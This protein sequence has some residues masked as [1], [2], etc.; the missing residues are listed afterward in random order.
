MPRPPKRTYQHFLFIATVVAVAVSLAVYSAKDKSDRITSQQHILVQNEF[1]QFFTTVRAYAKMIVVNQSIETNR[2]P[3]IFE[4]TYLP[5]FQFRQI[6]STGQELIKFDRFG[7]NNLNDISTR[8]YW[9]EISSL[10]PGDWHVTPAQENWENDSISGE[11]IMTASNTFRFFHL[12]EERI[13]G[14][15]GSYLAFNV[16]FSRLAERFE[17]SGL[18]L[19]FL[20]ER[21]SA[22]QHYQVDGFE[23]LQNRIVHIAIGSRKYP[24][25]T[26]TSRYHLG[27]TVARTILAI[28]LSAL[29]YWSYLRKKHDA[30]L[31]LHL[32]QQQNLFTTNWI[33]MASHYFRHPVANI[34]SSLEL[35]IL[36]GIISKDNKQVDNIFS[37]LEKFITIFNHIQKMNVLNKLEQRDLVDTSIQKIVDLLSSKCGDRLKIIVACDPNCML[38]IDRETFLWALIEIVENAIQHGETE[39]VSL[40]IQTF[41]NTLRIYVIDDGVGMPQEFIEQLNQ[42]QVKFKTDGMDSGNF[43]LGYY[44]VFRIMKQHEFHIAVESSNEQGTTIVIEVPTT[45]CFVP[46]V[47]TEA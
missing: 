17:Y 16:D 3:D 13:N 28:I 24:I 15:Q 4:D 39:H 44:Q 20:K 23:L 14:E 37:S 43:G 27:Y 35:L 12:M 7:Y 19:C 11:V 30:D 34:S 32:E 41:K 36:K 9:K 46:V 31:K 18:H 29:L 21:N 8:T 6:S 10:A 42:E 5:I 33:N 40:K 25:L 45:K 22:E 47:D 26:L 2:I 38:T 1:N